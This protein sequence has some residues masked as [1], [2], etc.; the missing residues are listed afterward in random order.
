[1]NEME[2]TQVVLQNP[3]Q[4][5][6][7]AL[8]QRE[9]GLLLRYYPKE[10]VQRPAVVVNGEGPVFLWCHYV[11]HGVPQKAAYRENDDNR[12]TQVTTVERKLVLGEEWI[13]RRAKIL[14]MKQRERVYELTEGSLHDYL[15]LAG[16]GK[17]TKSVTTRIVSA[18]PESLFP[19][20]EDAELPFVE[21]LRA[22]ALFAENPAMLIGEIQARIHED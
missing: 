22:W 5:G 3:F 18:E 8:L 11:I 10:E 16:G 13:E 12:R 2:P 14:T 1:M 21:L 17:F 15:V 4:D 6:S 19:I 7:I 20:L 9:N